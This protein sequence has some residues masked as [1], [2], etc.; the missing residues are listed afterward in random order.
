[1]TKQPP[2]RHS[3]DDLAQLIAT[4]QRSV[5]SGDEQHFGIRIG[6]NGQW[7]YL[8][9]PINRPALPKL[10]ATVLKRDDAGIFWLETPVE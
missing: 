8:G 4:G 2:N 3:P 6:R 5:T 10:F 9:T 7:Y 1:M